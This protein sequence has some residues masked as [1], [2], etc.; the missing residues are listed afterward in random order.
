MVGG[1]EGVHETSLRVQLQMST[2]FDNFHGTY[3]NVLSATIQVLHDI[4]WQFLKNVQCFGCFVLHLN[5]MF[6]GLTP[7]SS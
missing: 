7:G 2:L 3:G 4:F 1:G 5:F 6:V